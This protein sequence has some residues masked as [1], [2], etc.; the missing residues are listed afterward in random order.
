MN[1]EN[2]Y[3]DV[4]R[5]RIITQIAMSVLSGATVGFAL[6]ALQAGVLIGCLGGLAVL[7]LVQVLLS[8]S[9]KMYLINQDENIPQLS[10][11]GRTETVAAA[12]LVNVFNTFIVADTDEQGIGVGP[13][14]VPAYRFSDRD[15][16]ALAVVEVSLN[17]HIQVLTEPVDPKDSK[18]GVMVTLTG[19]PHKTPRDHL[20]YWQKTL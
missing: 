4:A 2:K 8:K 9:L 11:L 19:L 3:S 7:V 5:S 16:L 1:Y 17:P 14:N 12:I 6:V 15:W 18:K 20:R 10:V 13:F